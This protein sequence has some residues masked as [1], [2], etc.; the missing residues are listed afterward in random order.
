M[1]VLVDTDWYL[2]AIAGT[3][4]Y[5]RPAFRKKELFDPTEDAW[6]HDKFNLAP[7]EDPDYDQVS[8]LRSEPLLV[9]GSRAP[10]PSHPPNGIF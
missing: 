6:V 10:L 3:F 8:S 5:R 9:A 7:E 4:W 1:L 2:L